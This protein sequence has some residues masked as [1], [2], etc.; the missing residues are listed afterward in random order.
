[1]RVL[2]GNR[3]NARKRIDCVLWPAWSRDSWD[4]LDAHCHAGFAARL[5]GGAGAE[6][7]DIHPMN[8]S[9]TRLSV[10]RPPIT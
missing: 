8:Q 3:S 9:H 7:G 6:T 1:M 5:I 2:L 10:Q 4:G